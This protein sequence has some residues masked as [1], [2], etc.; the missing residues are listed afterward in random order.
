MC[1]FCTKYT[2]ARLRHIQS[3]DVFASFRNEKFEFGVY[4][5]EEGLQ[6]VYLNLATFLGVYTVIYSL[7]WG[8]LEVGY[9]NLVRF[10]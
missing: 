6:R 10:D 3:I 1:N 7:S 5:G 4:F 9:N 2:C 8:G